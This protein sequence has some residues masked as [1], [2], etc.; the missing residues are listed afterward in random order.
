M[1][2]AQVAPLAPHFWYVASQ[3]THQ[4]ELGRAFAGAA[5]QRIVVSGGGEYFA[6]GVYS[7]AMFAYSFVP[8][9]FQNFWASKIMPFLGSEI[10]TSESFCGSNPFLVFMPKI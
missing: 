1:A 8:R 10:R 2:N 6:E 9:G 3:T 7:D 5:T 4:G